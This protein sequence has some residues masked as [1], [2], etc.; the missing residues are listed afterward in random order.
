MVVHTIDTFSNGGD[1]KPIIWGVIII[2][3]VVCTLSVLCCWNRAQGQ[4]G[5][6]LS[7]YMGQENLPK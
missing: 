2:T 6:A 1:K 4:W 5:F 7:I 3:A